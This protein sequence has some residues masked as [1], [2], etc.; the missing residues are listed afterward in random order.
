MYQKELIYLGLLQLVKNNTGIGFLNNADQGHPTYVLGAKGEDPIAGHND[1]S[2]KSKLFQMLQSL[3]QDLVKNG[4]DTAEVINNQIE[5]WQDFCKLAVDS[6]NQH[7][8][9]S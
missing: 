1:S 7:R 8:E 4:C 9:Q 5:T 2:G 3:S 6:Y